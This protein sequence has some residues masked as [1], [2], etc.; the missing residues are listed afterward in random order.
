MGD[1]L[2]YR[3]PGEVDNW[4]DENHDPI[5]RFKN[6][7]IKEEI[8]SADAVEKIEKEARQICEKRSICNE[9]PHPSLDSLM[10]DLYVE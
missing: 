2:T 6:Y 5:L 1:P 7:L 9:S 4:K 10:E 8:M 3:K